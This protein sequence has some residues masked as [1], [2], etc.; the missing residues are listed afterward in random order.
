[1][2]QPHIQPGRYRHY[3]GSYYWVFGVV[4]DCSTQEVLVLYGAKDPQWVRPLTEFKERVEFDG[5]KV[6]RF[7][8][9]P[10]IVAV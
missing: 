6:A 8:L 2:I 5:K 1:M 4:R 7:E 9:L 10:D 3:K